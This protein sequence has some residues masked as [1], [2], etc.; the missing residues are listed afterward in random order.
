M[1][2]HE[3][4]IVVEGQEQ[5][6]SRTYQYRKVGILDIDVIA[7]LSMFYRVDSK[8]LCHFAARFNFNRINEFN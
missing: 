1:Q 5:P 4:I 8:L 7:I 3:Q 6:I 2:M